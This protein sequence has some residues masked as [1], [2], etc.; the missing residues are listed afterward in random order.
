[1]R[2]SFFIKSAFLAYIG[3]RGLAASPL[4]AAISA[5]P[6]PVRADFEKLSFTSCSETAQTPTSEARS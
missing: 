5:F 6:T 4:R 1:T 2:H 3:M